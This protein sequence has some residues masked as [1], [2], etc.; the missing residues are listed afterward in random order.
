MKYYTICKF[1]PTSHYKR[2]NQKGAVGRYEQAPIGFVFHDDEKALELEEIRGALVSL[3]Y[4]VRKE[5]EEGSEDPRTI[6]LRVDAHTLAAT[7]STSG[8]PVPHRIRSW[9]KDN[10]LFPLPNDEPLVK[11]TDY[12]NGWLVSD[13]TNLTAP[14]NPISFGDLYDNC[15]QLVKLGGGC[16]CDLLKTGDCMEYTVLPQLPTSFVGPMSSDYDVEQ[17]WLLRKRYRDLM[18]FEYVKPSYTVEGDFS[19]AMRPYDLHDFALV[20]QRKAEFAARG[21]KRKSHNHRRETQCSLCYFSSI[22]PKGKVQDCGYVYNCESAVTQLDAWAY[23]ETRYDRLGFETM[24]NFTAKERDYLIHLG[25]TNV[26]TTA[27]TGNQAISGILAGFV[28]TTRGWGFQLSPTRGC[29]DRQGVCH[30]YEEVYRS[31]ANTSHVAAPDKIPKVP[32]VTKRVR[33]ACALLAERNYVYVWG[34][35]AVNHYRT[36]YSSGVGGCV[37]RTGTNTSS[38]EMGRRTITIADAASHWFDTLGYPPSNVALFMP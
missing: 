12:L 15:T 23:L 6:V 34:K 31:L 35:G 26:K 13:V 4:L 11:G 2:W 1:T 28:R 17:S 20:A 10:P 7:F 25:N 14:V 36:T 18:G 30:S 27:I 32:H 3:F 19:S 24:S 8:F 5:H 21:A 22:S 16:P 33:M 29:L 9:N 37:T 38:Y